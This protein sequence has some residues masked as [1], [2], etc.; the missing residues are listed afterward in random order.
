MRLTFSGRKDAARVSFER[1]LAWE[2]DK[3]ILAHHGH[4]YDRDGAAELR[5]AFRRLDPA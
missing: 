4:W 3:V 1:M 5:R 2:P